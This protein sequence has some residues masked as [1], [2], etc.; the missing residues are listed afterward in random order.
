MN[1]DTDSADSCKTC[2]VRTCKSIV[3]A[4]IIKLPECL[5]MKW[6]GHF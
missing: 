4:H 2:K 6:D 3:D 1:M 5:I